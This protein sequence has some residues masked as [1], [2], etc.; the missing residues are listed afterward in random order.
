[1]SPKFYG[2]ALRANDFKFELKIVTVEASELFQVVSQVFVHAPVESPTFSFDDH[3][4]ITVDLSVSIYVFVYFE[5]R[6]FISN[7]F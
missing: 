6:D 2:V 1:M 4:S 7:K 5:F 3:Y